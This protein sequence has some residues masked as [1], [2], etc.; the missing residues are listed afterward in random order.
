M[1]FLCVSSASVRHVEESVKDI[2]NSFNYFVITPDGQYKMMYLSRNLKEQI[3]V[4]EKE[5]IR[6]DWGGENDSWV[7]SMVILR[8]DGKKCFC[9]DTKTN[10]EHLMFDFGLQK[11][12]FFF[13]DF[14]NTEYEVTDVRDTIIHGESR[15]LIELRGQDGKSDIWLEREG[16]SIRAS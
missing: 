1:A 10:T 14:D 5:Y 9:F 15:L 4:D 6:Y 11:G 8:Q 2:G 16:L 12:D 7:D 13:D 3:V